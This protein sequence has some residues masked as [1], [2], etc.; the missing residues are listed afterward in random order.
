MRRGDPA[1][2]EA[3]L[4]GASQQSLTALSQ[5]HA[6]LMGLVARKGQRQSQEAGQR[7]PAVLVQA[8][9][10][11]SSS[12]SLAVD[13]MQNVKALAAQ[14]QGPG[15]GADAVRCPLSARAPLDREAKRI[16]ALGA[17]AR[18][19][20]SRDGRGRSPSGQEESPAAASSRR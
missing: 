18:E 11:T 15:D 1:T 2:A 19:G 5:A 17:G 4:G 6:Q 16:H 8:M 7:A 14:L 20:V 3:S 9:T 13:P 12:I 10:S